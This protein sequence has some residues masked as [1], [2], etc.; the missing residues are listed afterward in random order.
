MKEERQTH[1]SF[2]QLS[3]HRIQCGGG[4]SLY[5]SSLKHGQIIRMTVYESEA[6]RDLHETRYHAGKA[7]IEIDMSPHQFAQAITTLNMGRGTPVTLV[8]RENKPIKECPHEDERELFTKEFQ[9]N[10]DNVNSAAKKLV[11][12]AQE[13]LNQKTIKVSDRKRLLALLGN[14]QR[15]IGSN[16]G[17]TNSMFQES[18]DK[19]VAAGKHEIE[20]FWR[21]MVEQMGVQSLADKA[22]PPQLFDASEEE[23]GNT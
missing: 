21:G 6:I 15:E 12:E 5:G 13:I 23:F 14:I 11:E 9:K 1:E 10:V 4:K 22:V 16:M 7:I 8:R 19:A 20:S 17:F 18:M 3:F 2:A